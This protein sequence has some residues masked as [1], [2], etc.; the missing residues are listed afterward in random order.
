M[1]PALAFYNHFLLFLHGCGLRKPN[2][3]LSQKPVKMATPPTSHQNSFKQ[4]WGVIPGKMSARMW[5]MGW[6]WGSQPGWED[7]EPEPRIPARPGMISKHITNPLSSPPSS[8]PATRLCQEVQREPKVM[9]GRSRAATPGR[10]LRLQSLPPP[11]PLSPARH[12]PR[13]RWA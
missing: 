1:V 5:V 11:L 6:K 13:D 7:V 8:F 2:I 10:T 9:T 3:T 4:R 12:L